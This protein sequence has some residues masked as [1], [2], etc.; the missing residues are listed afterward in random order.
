MLG[1][2]TMETQCIHSLLLPSSCMLSSVLLLPLDRCWKILVPISWPCP[3]PS[4]P[5][6]STGCALGICHRAAMWLR[7]DMC[8]CRAKVCGQ[9]MFSRWCFLAPSNI[10]YALGALFKFSS[11]FSLSY[12]STCWYL[13]HSS[14]RTSQPLL[15]KLWYMSNLFLQL[16]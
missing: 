4:V 2:T 10:R 7:F 6:R 5:E 1:S 14:F 3:R 13:S 12:Q 8:M 9:G 11:F 15:L 16:I